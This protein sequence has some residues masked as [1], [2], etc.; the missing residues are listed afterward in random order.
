MLSLFSASA[1]A[2]PVNVNTA[3]AN[4]LADN[5]KGVGSKIAAKITSYRE[6]NGPFATVDELQ[7]VKGVGPK[8]IEKNRDVL[9]IEGSFSE[10]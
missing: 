4:S 3:N 2:G 8:T 10:E 6:A 5:I 1:F 9:N 7:Q